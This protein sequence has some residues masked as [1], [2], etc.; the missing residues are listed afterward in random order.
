LDGGPCE[1][2][3]ESTI[4]GFEQDNPVVYRLGGIGVEA[5]ER[6]V[7]KLSWRTHSTSN[8]R[9]PGQMQSHYAPRKK[10]VV[11]KIEELLQHYP[12]HRTGILS[13]HQNFNCPYQ[14]IL[15]PSGHIEEAAQNL[16]AGLRFFDKSPVET[17]V[18]EW[19]PDT[20]IGRAI[21]D[22]LA[23]AAAQPPD[24]SEKSG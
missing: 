19:V 18:A 6:I 14:F 11:G 16:F 10:V 22:R 17:I 12:A 21:N 24:T 3:V 2:G 23:R 20:G 4:V 13:F 8:P 1:V 5:L 7:G 9:A 15:S